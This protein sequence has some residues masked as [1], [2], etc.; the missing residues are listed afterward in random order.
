[1]KNIAKTV[2]DVIDSFEVFIPVD[3]KS[4]NNNDLSKTIIFGMESATIIGCLYKSVFKKA[5]PI[6][7]VGL[8]VVSMLANYILLKDN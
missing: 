6:V 4:T 8:S 1:M 2:Y 3:T 7:Y 5:N